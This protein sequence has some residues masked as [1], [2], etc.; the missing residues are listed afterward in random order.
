MNA[1]LVERDWPA[2]EVMH[3]LLGLPL[4]ESS[5]TVISINVRAPDQQNLI[6]EIHDGSV[7]KRG[8]SWLE[9]YLG[10]M[11]CIPGE[12]VQLD[13]LTFFDFA[14]HYGIQKGCLIR[15]SQARS[16]ILRLYPSYSS[17]PGEDGY[18]DYC[19]A[20]LMLHHLFQDYNEIQ[21]S[22]SSYE[23]ALQD[24]DHRGCYHPQNLLDPLDDV[25]D[26]DESED[27]SDKK[28]EEP[29]SDVQDLW[30][31]L[32]ARN[33]LKTPNHL[34]EENIN[35]GTRAQDQAYD[36][37]KFSNIYDEY[38]EQQD[39]YDFAKLLEVHSFQKLHN[40]DTLQTA[41]HI[42]FDLVMANYEQELVNGYS[43]QLF[44]HID[45]AA[46]TGKSY[47]IEII[48]A[49]LKEKASQ[50]YKTDTVLREAPTGVAEKLIFD[51]V[52]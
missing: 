41:Q 51:R 40:P 33:A 24:C 44:L 26:E 13:Q 47:L 27:E 17:T 50:H 3:H 30:I 16:R 28:D 46:G 6:L 18:E 52:T 7:Q 35:L 48:S 39:F 29:D 15:R 36:W 5:R 34:L 22:F 32:A 14:Q 2:Q 4:V 42:C 37:Q 21:G 10:R 11:T 25:S 23:A 19:R 43:S 1:L 12:G 9:K 49:H 31:A 20:K 38:G 45:G 8:K